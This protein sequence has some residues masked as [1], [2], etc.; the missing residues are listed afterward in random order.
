MIKHALAGL[1][2]AALILQPAIAADKKTDAKPQETRDKVSYSIGVDIGSNFKRG[3]LDLNPDFL[4]KGI[5]DAYADKVLMTEEEMRET[6]M[7]FQAEMQEKMMAKMK[8]AAEKNAKDSE[9][10]LAENKKKEGVKTTE[11]G[12]QFKVITEGKGAKPVAGDVVAINYVGTLVNGTK[13]D[14][15]RD[16]PAMFPLEGIIPGFAEALL[17]MPVGSKW[18]V[19][20]PPALAYGENAPPQIGP[21][22]VLIFDI[23]LLEIKK[24]EPAPEAPKGE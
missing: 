23:E 22:Q 16:G 19:V 17:M 12:L 6:L 18:Q 14:E 3:E 9:K 13:F 10:F 24:P 11:S 2:L 7:K 15:N 8:A 20:I 1:A 5:L 21:N 4:I